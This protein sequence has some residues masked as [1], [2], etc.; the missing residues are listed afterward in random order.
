MLGRPR[1]ATCNKSSSS[2]ALI[3]LSQFP[4]PQHCI[5]MVEAAA[6][7]S[8]RA[9]AMQPLLDPQSLMRCSG[10]SSPVASRAGPRSW[11]LKPWTSELQAEAKPET[12]VSELRTQEIPIS[13]SIH[14]RG[15][16]IGRITPDRVLLAASPM[17]RVFADG[18]RPEIRL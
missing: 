9:A 11:A 1:R 17:R 5:A 3:G 14:L 15:F 2:W 16:R 8:V 4:K 6:P 10:L 12:E 7:E 13:E 18:R